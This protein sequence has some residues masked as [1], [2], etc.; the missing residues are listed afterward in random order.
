MENEIHFLRGQLP[1]QQINLLAAAAPTQAVP[2]VQSSRSVTGHS[3]LQETSYHTT[4]WMEF[5]QATG[6]TTGHL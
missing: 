6:S 5:R 4:P 1:S 3:L 2:T